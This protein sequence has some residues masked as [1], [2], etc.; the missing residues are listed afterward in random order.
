MSCLSSGSHVF[1]FSR[2]CFIIDGLLI[3]VFSHL[4][5]FWCIYSCSLC[6]NLYQSRIQSYRALMKLKA[7]GYSLQILVILLW[8]FFKCKIN[9]HLCSS[10]PLNYI[11]WQNIFCDS[12]CMCGICLMNSVKTTFSSWIIPLEW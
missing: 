5:S 4:I 8:T 7:Q 12:H 2:T 1:F 6:L 11:V 10:H 3:C 9:W